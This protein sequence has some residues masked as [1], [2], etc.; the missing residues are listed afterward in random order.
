MANFETVIELEGLQV[1]NT[2]PFIRITNKG[3]P[4][5]FIEFFSQAQ[6][7]GTTISANGQPANYI[8]DFTNYKIHFSDDPIPAAPPHP[9][10]G[11]FVPVKPPAIGGIK[12]N[13]P[14]AGYFGNDGSPLVPVSNQGQVTGFSGTAKNNDKFALCLS[15][16]LVQAPGRVNGSNAEWLMGH[17][18]IT[19]TPSDQKLL[20]S[21]FIFTMGFCPSNDLALVSLSRGNVGIVI[22]IDL[23]PVVPQPDGSFLGY[24]NLTRVLIYHDDIYSSDQA[25]MQFDSAA[26][27]IYFPAHATQWPVLDS[28]EYFS[29]A[30][31]TVLATLGVPMPA[32][33]PLV[34]FASVGFGPPKTLNDFL[35]NAVTVLTPACGTL[36]ADFISPNEPDMDPLSQL[37]YWLGWHLTSGLGNPSLNK[38]L[39]DLYNA[40]VELVK[41]GKA[42]RGI[43]GGPD[44]DPGSFAQAILKAIEA[45]EA[46][47]S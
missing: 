41:T 20:P 24:A 29:V 22:D 35:K 25:Q 8:V 21:T 14:Q 6:A 3:L 11:P 16:G 30:V 26:T 12:H 32:E 2:P 46:R 17:V 40:D 37:A 39:T 38:M 43:E 4:A 19:K 5:N 10:V 44:R 45:W 34:N 1:S 33:T 36:A 27:G 47:Q 31:S 9:P 15:T 28:L 23:S 13:P 18:R 7:P 42:G